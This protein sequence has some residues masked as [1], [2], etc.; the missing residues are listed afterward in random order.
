MI[1]Q[2]KNNDAYQRLKKFRRTWNRKPILRKIYTKWYKKISNYLLSG[3]TLEIGSGIGNF[4]K[5]K[6]EIISSDIIDCE[7]LDKCFD[8]HKIPYLENSL[9]NITMIDVFHHLSD[10]TLFLEEAYRVLK[11][12]GRII[13]IEPFP[14]AISHIIYRKFHPEPF[15]MELGNKKRLMT[16]NPWQANQALPYLYFFKKQSKYLDEFKNKFKILKREKFCF[17][18]Y[19]LSGGFERNQL[20]PDFLLPFTDKLEDLLRPM[21]NL[22]SFRCFIVVEKI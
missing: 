4:K 7:W 15:I 1:S 8:A 22:L 9:S 10:P 3:K 20:I 19:P 12:K 6:P 5:F 16:K 17:F 21:R 11:T 13:M 14:S 18:G 2:K